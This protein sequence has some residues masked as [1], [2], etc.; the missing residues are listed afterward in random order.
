MKKELSKG[1]KIAIGV[2]A[3]VIVMAAIGW[4]VALALLYTDIKTE[5]Y[6]AEF[7]Y[8]DNVMYDN[9]YITMKN[10]KWQLY[11]DGGAISRTFGRLEYVDDEGRFEF[12]NT[13]GKGWGYVDTSGGIIVE[14]TQEYSRLVSDRSSLVGI[15]VGEEE[16]FVRNG[17]NRNTRIEGKPL[18]QSEFPA[19]YEAYGD[20]YVVYR[21]KNGALFAVGTA[22]FEKHEIGF[23]PSAT[24]A[25]SDGYLTLTAASASTFGPDLKKVSFLDGCLPLSVGESRG[26][27]VVGDDAVIY[28]DD[29]AGYKCTLSGGKSF[30]VER[31][32]KVILTDGS[33]AVIAVT[34][35]DYLYFDGSALAAMT[36]VGEEELLGGKAWIFKTRDEK[37]L[38]FDEGCGKVTASEMTTATLYRTKEKNRARYT[39][40]V[41]FLVADGKIYVRENGKNTVKLENVVGIVSDRG[42]TDSRIVTRSQKDGT[43]IYNSLFEVTDR[44]NKMTDAKVIDAFIPVYAETGNG[45]QTVTMPR[46]SFE[47]DVGAEVIVARCTNEENYY[48]LTGDGSG[49]YKV[50]GKNGAPCGSFAYGENERVIFSETQL[51]VLSP[52][53][54]NIVTKERVIDVDYDE[55]HFGMFN[56]YAVA[57]GGGMMYVVNLND[58][59]LSDTRY[60]RD[61]VEIVDYND[62]TFI[63]RDKENGLYGI[64][65]GGKVTLSPTYRQMRLYGDFVIASVDESGQS[66]ATYFQSDFS[67]KRISDVYR[68]LNCTEGLTLGSEDGVEYEITNARG[69]VILK[70]V[71]FVP[72]SPDGGFDFMESYVYDEETGR[73]VPAYRRNNSRLLVVT[74]GGCKRVISITRD[75]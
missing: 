19:F 54:I 14:F 20:S 67:G 42:S 36:K 9:A 49:R 23:D 65:S 75:F 41:K 48:A 18:L 52:D 8:V 66:G 47:T 57:L 24:Y 34:D 39:V 71:T 7:D 45:K 64:V 46:G 60:L 28:T 59:T 56:R 10:G 13:D 50:Y 51:I 61:D 35:T 62:S 22:D 55:I 11:R 3:F 58:G 73:T 17:E 6:G 4:I 37:Y 70:H 1:V 43:V 72:E 25:A 32:A 68:E 30:I 31:G 38:A 33:E 63:Y 21:D 27:D 40:G 29:V 74:A 53:K 2:A 16:F 5:V 26:Y 12:I 44:K 69:R 15:R